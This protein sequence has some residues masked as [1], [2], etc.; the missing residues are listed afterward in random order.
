MKQLLLNTFC[1][2]LYFLGLP[3]QASVVFDQ[4][5]NVSNGQHFAMEVTFFTAIKPWL[6]DGRRQNSN[7]HLHQRIFTLE[8][9]ATLALR[10]C[11]DRNILQ[12]WHKHKTRH[13][14]ST[15]DYFFLAVAEA[16]GKGRKTSALKVK[17][18]GDL[19]FNFGQRPSVDRCTPPCQ[20]S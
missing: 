1:I 3:F 16:E 14:R 12:K 5:H 19:I 18:E 20:C 6:V 17:A 11:G 13:Q 2:A 4:W 7:K 8:E 10:W 15:K 9:Q